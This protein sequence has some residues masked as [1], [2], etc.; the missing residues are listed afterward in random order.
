MASQDPSPTSLLHVFL[1]FLGFLPTTIVAIAVTT[2]NPNQDEAA[3][4]ANPC[5]NPNF[6]PPVLQLSNFQY[7]K[8]GNNVSPSSTLIG[9]ANFTVIDIAN[10]NGNGDGGGGGGSVVECGN[11]ELTGG[12]NYYT[13]DDTLFYHCEVR[14]GEK[15]RGMGKRAVK[16]GYRFLYGSGVV[17][18]LMQWACWDSY[19]T[20]GKGGESL[21]L[22]YP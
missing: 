14:A 21:G 22:G 17:Q 9:A 19:S 15:G 2:P 13:P 7:R 20:A 6:N 18:V 12:I 16:M 8:S 3:L 11:A 5:D 10:T 4:N 1:L